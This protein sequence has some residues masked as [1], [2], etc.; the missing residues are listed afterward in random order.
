MLAGCRHMVKPLV[1]F[2][3]T[4]VP[5]K[6]E[7]C[8]DHDRTRQLAAFPIKVGREERDHERDQNHGDKG[9][10]DLGREY[11][12]EDEQDQERPE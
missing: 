5:R 9:V 12:G 2:V 1:P 4:L 3:F 7:S 10:L 8:G 11:D 6:Q